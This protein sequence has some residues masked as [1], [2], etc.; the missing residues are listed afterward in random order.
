[1][2]HVATLLTI[3]VL[4]SLFIITNHKNKDVGKQVK[5]NCKCL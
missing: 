5:E 2:R 1:M 3:L 4:N